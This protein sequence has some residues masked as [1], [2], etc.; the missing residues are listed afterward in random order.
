LWNSNRLTPTRGCVDWFTFACAQWVEVILYGAIPGC[1]YLSLIEGF[2]RVVM[3]WAMSC[4]QI[5]WVLSLIVQLNGKKGLRVPIHGERWHWVTESG[6]SESVLAS[7]TIGVSKASEG[8]G[9][10]PLKDFGI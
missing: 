7:V 8:I 6:L 10:E 5:W 1:L 9:L 3:I 4:I 2:A